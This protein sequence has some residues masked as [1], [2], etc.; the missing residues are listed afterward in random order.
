[1]IQRNLSNCI[2]AVVV[3]ILLIVLFS[4]MPGCGSVNKAKQSESMSVDSTH[5]IKSKTDIHRATD[6]TNLKTENSFSGKTLTVEF[7]TS[8]FV[9][10]SNEFTTGV[11]KV[12]AGVI[13]NSDSGT[14]RIEF[15]NAIPKK[16]TVKDYSINKK[17]DSTATHSSDTSNFKK[18]DSKATKMVAKDSQSTTEKT[19]RSTIWIWF[20]VVLAAL[21]IIYR[22]RWQI[23]ELFK[24]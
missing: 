15:G 14:F 22:Y 21:A 1:M 20:I 2:L 9:I 12:P 3:S 11:T 8:N 19:G 16:I 18:S 5:A 6:S 23:L 24:K 10:N 17:T 7:D 4:I 13:Y